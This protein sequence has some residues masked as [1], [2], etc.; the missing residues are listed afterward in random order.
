MRKTADFF[1][2]LISNPEDDWGLEITTVG[3]YH[4]APHS[5]YPPPGHP[6]THTFEWKNGRRLDEYQIIYVPAGT[7]CLEIQGQRSDVRAGDLIL[8]HKGDWHRYRPDVGKGWETYWVGFKGPYIEKYVRNRLFSSSTSISRTIRHRTE[9]ISLFDQLIDLSKRDEALFKRVALGAL[10]QIVAHASLPPCTESTA[11]P[12]ATISEKA[13]DF[14]RQNMF[15]DIDF[16]EL[17][18]SFGLSYSRFRSL[19]KQDTGLAPH[20]FLLNE[21]IA[22]AKR[23]LRDP[24]IEI[25]TIGYKAGFQSPSYFS[26]LFRRKT[27]LTPSAARA[28]RE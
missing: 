16:R 12:P 17:A 1:T 13:V 9:L 24:A 7:G 10:L 26:R 18:S 5:K 27:G 23:L 3:Y 20:Q 14:M 6:K 4:A 22:C 15:T 8:L 19:F 2:Y 28:S 21:R 25:K 11:R